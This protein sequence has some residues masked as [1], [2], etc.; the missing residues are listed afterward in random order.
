MKKVLTAVLGLGL[1]AS[2]FA[3]GKKSDTTSSNKTT[4]NSTTTTTST[5]K[6]NTTKA[7]TAKGKSTTK[8]TKKGTTTQAKLGEMPRIDI[9]TSDGNNDFATVPTKDSKWDYTPC[10]VTVNDG[11]DEVLTSI[12][13]GVKVRGNWTANYDKKP[14]RIK[15]DKKQSMLGLNE[16]QKF[17][18]WLLLAEYKDWSMLRNATAFG[19]ASKLGSGYVSDYKFVEVY[20]NNEYWGVYLLCEQQEIKEGRVSITEAE[21]EYTGTDIGYLLEYDGYYTEEAPEET[22]T[23][24]YNTLTTYSGRSFSTFQK[25][26]TIKSDIYSEAQNTFIKNYM[27]N[28]FNICYNAIYNDTY[29]EFNSDYTNIVL[30]ST[31]T[32]AEAAVDKVI[33]IDSLVASYILAELGCDTDVAWSSFF[34]DVDF[35]EYG[36]K[37]LTFEAPWDFDSGFGNTIACL[38]AEGIYA[39]D[40][41]RDIHDTEQI[42][43]WYVLFINENWFRELVK[44]KWNQMMETNA[45]DSVF[46]FIL[47]VTETYKDNFTENYAKWKNIGIKGESS[48]YWIEFDYSEAGKCKTHE[49]AAQCLYDWLALRI[50]NLDE[51]FNSTDFLG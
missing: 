13:A 5:T 48:I 33:D 4:K 35:G 15:F 27:Q 12:D 20:L 16:G 43:P 10:S 2:L 41:I 11:V 51:I 23:I 32:N 9:T 21:K 49:E 30:S 6:G 29:Y 3:C 1:C 37:K 47:D 19:L 39:G 24:N 50:D 26:F 31:I 14:L 22:F 45:F 17:K 40:V 25:G 8:T 44:T 18:S 42:N 7:S 36:N 34:M 38:D 28:V 46:E